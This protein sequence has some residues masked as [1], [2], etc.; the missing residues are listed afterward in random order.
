[1]R[2][3]RNQESIQRMTAHNGGVAAAERGGGDPRALT[4]RQGTSASNSPNLANMPPTTDDEATVDEQ[5]ASIF[6]DE[7]MV[8][9]GYFGK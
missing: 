1:M 4:P 9:V 8:D 2:N 3:V 6:R 5:A 7:V